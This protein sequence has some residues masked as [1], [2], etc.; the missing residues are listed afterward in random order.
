MIKVPEEFAFEDEA[1]RKRIEATP[2]PRLQISIAGKVP[3]N[4]EVDSNNQR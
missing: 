2:D 1:Q 3:M 4:S